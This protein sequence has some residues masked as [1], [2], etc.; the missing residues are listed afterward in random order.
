MSRFFAKP[1]SLAIFLRARQPPRYRFPTLALN[2]PAANFHTTAKAAANSQAAGGTKAAERLASQEE[3][4]RLVCYH[5]K[6]N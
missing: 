4:D 3:E 2:G 5:A 1:V 6:N